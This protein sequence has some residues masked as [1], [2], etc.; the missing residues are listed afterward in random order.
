VADG[1]TLG[2]SV[3]E[4]QALLADV[5][6]LLAGVGVDPADLT[7]IVVG[8]GPGSF[9]GTRIGLA[10][11]RGLGLSLDL[12]VAGVST[13]RALA[14]GA[15]GAFPIVDAKRGEVFVEGPRAVPPTELVVPP[16]VVC[17]G[18]GA[19]RYRDV[20]VARGADVA[21]DDSPLHVPWASLH[22]RLATTFGPADAVE[23]VYVR[24]PDAH[25]WRG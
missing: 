25:R 7:G 1:D 6:A 13:L 21:P 11:A 22:A 5:D 24:V 18:N 15:E 9:T 16:G 19:C 20:L 4:P 14:A 17:V 10:V 12:D 2:E 3:T 8:T 23:P